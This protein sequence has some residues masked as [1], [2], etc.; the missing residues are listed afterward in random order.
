[1][2]IYFR[3]RGK[4]K[5]YHLHGGQNSKRVTLLDFRAFVDTQLNQ[6]T[7]H[8]S[9]DLA[10]VARISLGAANVLNSSLL[11]S[12]GNLSDFTVH[13]EEDFT[14]TGLLAQRTDSKKLE[15]KDLALLQ[16]YVKLLTDF[17]SRKEVSG[18]QD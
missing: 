3:K 6:Y 15:D 4:R 2:H 14:K 16:L 9:T 8:G 1:M 5:T 7:R 13:F 17:W 10:G 18:R 12:D 11:V